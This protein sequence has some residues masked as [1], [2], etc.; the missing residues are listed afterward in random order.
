MAK[1]LTPTARISQARRLIQ[2][3]K[4]LP[5]PES[6]GWEYFSYVAQVKDELR[7]AF[8]LVKLIGYSPST[9]EEVKADAKAVME[10]IEIAKTDILKSSKQVSQE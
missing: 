3:A 8:E 7:K 10:E 2:G 4:D 9:P 5:V 6:A 1:S